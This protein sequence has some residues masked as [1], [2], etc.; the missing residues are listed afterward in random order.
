MVTATKD[1]GGDFLAKKSGATKARHKKLPLSKVLIIEDEERDLNRL[2]ATLNL[3]FSYELEIKTAATL[4]AALDAAIGGKPDLIFLDD[5]LKPSDNADDTI[6][7]L[8]HAGYDGPIVVISSRATRK[9]KAQLANAGATDI[10]HKDDVDSVRMS[11]ALMRVFPSLGE[12][13]SNGED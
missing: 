5:V 6:P 8:R 1:S 3:M 7:Y 4:S 9:R 10:I 12:E 13:D 2:I 11:E